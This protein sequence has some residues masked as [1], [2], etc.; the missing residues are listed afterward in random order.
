MKRKIR[1]K[2]INQYLGVIAIVVVE[3]VHVVGKYVKLRLSANGLNLEE[4][5]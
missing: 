3:L 1:H 5:G 2:H 4:I